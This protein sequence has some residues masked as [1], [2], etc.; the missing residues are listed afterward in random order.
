MWGASGSRHRGCYHR[1]WG[2]LRRSRWSKVVT[3]WSKIMPRGACRGQGLH[4][5]TQGPECTSTPRWHKIRG[6]LPIHRWSWGTKRSR[7]RKLRCSACHSWLC[8]SPWWSQPCH[9]VCNKDGC[10]ENECDKVI[11]S[12]QTE[13]LDLQNSRMIKMVKV[14]FT[15]ASWKP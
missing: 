12:S 6:C 15:M 13:N 11:C 2:S 9:C 5:G 4:R 1:S 8:W 7:S 14:A 10:D 3:R